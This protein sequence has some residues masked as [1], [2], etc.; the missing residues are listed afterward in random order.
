M[1][2]KY[3][4][5]K[6]QPSDCINIDLFH[7]IIDCPII[8]FKRAFYETIFFKKRFEKKKKNQTYFIHVS[9]FREPTLFLHRRKLTSRQ[10]ESS[11]SFYNITGI[12]A[13]EFLI[14]NVKPKCADSQKGH[15]QFYR[16][17]T[18]LGDIRVLLHS[19][20]SPDFYPVL[21]VAIFTDG[22]RYSSVSSTLDSSPV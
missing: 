18:E 11:P 21:E 8:A 15:E 10:V 3:Y 13:L 22:H 16:K 12:S 20:C 2:I 14:K 7:L 5:S 9:Y 1:N 6:S 4:S 19:L 17:G